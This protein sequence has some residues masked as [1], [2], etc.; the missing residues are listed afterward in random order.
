MPAGGK[1]GVRVQAAHPALGRGGDQPLDE[2]FR[3][4]PLQIGDLRLLGRAAVE[5]EAA[6]GVQE[7]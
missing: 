5:I 2:G 1:G 4:H 3:V 6:F 7:A